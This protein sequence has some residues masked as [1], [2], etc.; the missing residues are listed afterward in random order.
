MVRTMFSCT[1]CEGLHQVAR[2]ERLPRGEFAWVPIAAAE[3]RQR[4]QR[5]RE[6]IRAMA[7]SLLV[8]T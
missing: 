5:V 8:R 7:V 2:S 4:A 3:K 6:H 1:R